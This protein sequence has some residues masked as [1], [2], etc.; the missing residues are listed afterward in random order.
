MYRSPANSY[1]VCYQNQKD[2][3]RDPGEIWIN[4]KKRA[5]E[6]AETCIATFVSP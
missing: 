6:A 2:S 3:L 1:T 4:A 5:M